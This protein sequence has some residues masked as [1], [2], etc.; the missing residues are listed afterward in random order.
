MD[1]LEELGISYDVCP[2]VSSF[3]GAAASLNMEFTLPG[4]SQTLIITRLA[5]RT[6]VPERESMRELAKHQASMAIF[7]SAGMMRQLSEELMAGGYP[8]D[9]P[10]A[11]VYKATWPD[12]KKILCTVG[13]MARRAE[14]AGLT[15]TTMILIGGAVAHACLLYTSCYFFFYCNEQQGRCRVRLCGIRKKFVD[16]AVYLK[17]LRRIIRETGK[18]QIGQRKERDLKRAQL[19]SPA[20]PVV[21]EYGFDVVFINGRIALTDHAE[22]QMC[23]RDRLYR[24]LVVRYPTPL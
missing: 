14:E 4:V 19:F 7:L 10:A 11:L 13:T 22:I 20:E 6:P 17:E 3:C 9:T 8:A 1:L 12:E 21:S 24:F 5:G 18:D 2:G 16:P 23:I 15:K